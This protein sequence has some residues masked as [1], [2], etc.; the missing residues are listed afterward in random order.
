MTNEIISFIKQYGAL[1]SPVLTITGALLNVFFFRRK[2]KKAAQIQELEQVKAGLLQEAA[3]DLLESGKIT[4]SELYKM[5]NF[6][7]IAKLADE[8]FK[9]EGPVEVLPEQDFDWHTRYY[10]A[11]G[12]VSDEDMQ[13]LWAKVLAGE[14]RR[15]GSYSLRTIEHLRNLTKEE[16]LLFLKVSE[17][18]IVIGNTVVLPR[19]NSYLDKKGIKYDDILKLEDCGL[20]KADPILSSSAQIGDEYACLTSN[21]SWAL[22]V[23]KRPG[24][25]NNSGRF[26]INEYL[27]TKSGAEL[28]S[29]IGV[30]DDKSFSDLC[31]VYNLESSKFEFANGQVIALPDG[32]KT[33][34]V[35][36]IEV[37]KGEERR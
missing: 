24:V 4:Y 1:A 26:E 28:Y 36:T 12:N 27:Y 20:I 7:Q 34:S 29:V 9:K 3:E 22:M 37:L 18:S 13:S 25:L 32:R 31:E 2:T 5:K 11:C 33:Y 15:P 16:A 23:R 30:S 14:I 6:M 8:E 21:N 10:E 19:M 17:S 35:M